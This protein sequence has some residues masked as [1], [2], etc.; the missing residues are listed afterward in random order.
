MSFTRKTANLTPIED[1]VFSIVKL[2]KEDKLK[3]GD[4]AIVDAT[5]GSLY[6]EN[7]KFVALKSVFENYDKI[8]AEIKAE[9]AASFV[10]NDSYREQ[11]VNW[12]FQNKKINLHKEVIATP[13]GS[14]AISLT[15]KNI[16]E[17]NQTVIIPNIAWGS[18]AL[19]ASQNNLNT[20]IYEMFDNDKFNIN[21]FKEKVIE[22]SK[23]QDKVLVVINDPCHNPTGYS[24]SISEW[25]EVIS[26]LNEISKDIPCVILNDIAYIDY[27]YNL[28][29][30]RDYL[31]TLNEMNENLM[32]IIAFSISK[33]LTSYGLRCGASLILCKNK[34][35][36]NEV[37]IVFEKGARATWSNIA[38]AAM[39]NFVYVTTNNLTNYLDEKQKYIDLLNQRASIFIN[40]ANECKLKIYPYKEGFFITLN[41][42][43]N[44][45]RDFLHKKLMDNHIYTV[46]VNKGIRIAI[47]ST[48]INKVK[49]LAY[50][51]KE[52]QNES[53]NK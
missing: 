43:D 7:G 42:A 18:Y 6:D 27:S 25:K 20:A 49:G 41:I 1:T 37:K 40:E 39:D 15:F 48:P 30:S 9:Y 47:C 51:I 29:K 32:C 53:K 5:I 38:N 13:G 36:V 22:V 33:S 35:Y 23:K 16:L 52:I 24:M 17:Q 26:F 34:T 8:P 28:E 11:V 14:G 44:K 19:M 4:D 10:G 2:A 50:K 46:C 21:S 12:V 45:E 3:N 31:L